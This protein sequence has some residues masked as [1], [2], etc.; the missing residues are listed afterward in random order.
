M[1]ASLKLLPD[2]TVRWRSRRYLIV[3]HQSLDAIIARQP[4]KG[5]LERIPVN[6]AAPDHASHIVSGR[7]PDLVSVPQKAWQTAVKR[8][9]ILKPLLNMGNSERTFVHVKKAARALGKH[10]ATVYRWIE[11]YGRSERLSVFRRKERSDRGTTRLATTVE[12]I[13]TKSEGIEQSRGRSRSQTPFANRI[14]TF[15]FISARSAR[16]RRYLWN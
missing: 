1:A 4:G 13:I 5:R 2:S 6:E 14:A 15:A 10:P 7:T 12:Q 11:N 9:E 16:I 3:D 8:F